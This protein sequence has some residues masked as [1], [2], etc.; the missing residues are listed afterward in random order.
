MS[1]YL[2][3]MKLRPLIF[4][5][6]NDKENN[7]LSK[8]KIDWT[9]LSM[10]PY[11]IYML[12]NNLT[13]INW[14]ELSENPNAI[15]ILENNLTEVDWSG[16]SINPNAIHIQPPSSSACLNVSQLCEA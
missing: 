4:S 9:F 8:Y 15:H 14:K 16:L 3:P 6:F 5:Y 12:E 13:E 11:A 2:P 1:Y 10:N 7:N